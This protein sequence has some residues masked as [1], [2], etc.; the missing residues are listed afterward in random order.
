MERFTRRRVLQG[1][2][3]AIAV[4]GPLAGCSNKSK[5]NNTEAA[6]LKVALPAYKPY[7]GVRP[8][9]A[10][11]AKGLQAGFYRYPAH[12]V[13]AF[14]GVPGKGGSVTAFT[15]LFGTPP[16]PE[17]KNKFWQQLN[18]KLG[19][20][21]QMTMSPSSDYPD[22]LAT[23][24]AGNDLPDMVQ[25]RGL[26]PQLPQLLTHDFQDLTEFVSKDAV[27]AYPMLANLAPEAWQ[28]M[29]FNGG[30]YGIP[31][32]R[33]ATGSLIYR[34]DDIFTAR[35]LDPNPTSFADFKKLCKALTNPQKNQFATA[36]PVGL[37]AF[38]SEMLGAPNSWREENGK[39]T[40]TIE[41]AETR[42]ALSETAALI[43][44]GVLHPD[45]F[46]KTAP[47]KDWLG[48]GQI[49]MLYDS[50]TAW[51]GYVTT[52]LPVNPKLDLGGMTPPNFDGNSK[53]V[54]WR[55]PPTFSMTALKK[56]KP[57][58]IKELLHILD[59]LSAPF[60][61]TEYLFRKYGI[62]GVDYTDKGTDPILTGTGKAETTLALLY[63][64]D[65][66]WPIYEPGHIDAAKKEHA[67]AEKAIPMTAADPTN[68]LFSDTWTSKA[69]SLATPVSNV[70]NDI[71][72]GRKPISAWDDAVKEWQQ[73]GGN[74]IRK[75]FEDSYAKTH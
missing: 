5:D 45:A 64:A 19:V 34:R 35:G 30:I 21:L 62:D 37:M 54:I 60:G 29:V 9:L 53:A 10:G 26:L 65:A 24:V 73:G 23:I 61:T 18:K 68:G 51:S 7:N 72:Q 42:R 41:T 59:W 43:K 28:A 48:N 55:G 63:L 4:G 27:A 31:V 2:G 1:T 49:A 67:Y 16:L 33:P 11:S 58:R 17:G 50:F 66:P 69:G 25:I 22:K 3:A 12:P 40:Y 38:I 14:N 71:L 39:F 57:A 15:A 75:E 13:P 74:Q 44:S 32:P 6:N 70:Q 20:D 8:D 36:S 56:A 46:L 52:Y 47:Q